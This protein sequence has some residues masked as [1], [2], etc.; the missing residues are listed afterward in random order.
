[1]YGKLVLQ[2]SSKNLN[3]VLALVGKLAAYRLSEL[4]ACSKYGEFFQ[5]QNVNPI[6]YKSSTIAFLY[7]ELVEIFVHMKHLSTNMSAQ[8]VLLCKMLKNSPKELAKELVTFCSMY[9]L[10]TK[11]FLF[12][13]FAKK[14][15]FLKRA[16]YGSPTSRSHVFTIND[17]NGNEIGNKGYRGKFIFFKFIDKS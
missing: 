3:M 1:M 11:D 12:K 2:C 15:L 9:L 4:T 7:S 6:Q 10:S 17:E 8:F 13:T 16:K 14:L 5:K